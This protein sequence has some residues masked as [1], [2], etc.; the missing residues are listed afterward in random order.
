MIESELDKSFTR[1]WSAL[2]A[3]GKD[4]TA[5]ELADAMVRAGW[6][7]FTVDDAMRKLWALKQRGDLP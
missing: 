4:G 7:E 6:D 5:T 1:A 3:S 2:V